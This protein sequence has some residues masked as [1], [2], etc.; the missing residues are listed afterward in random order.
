MATP[1]LSRVVATLLRMAPEHLIAW[2]G[3]LGVALAVV[4]FFYR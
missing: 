2:F 4:V 1:H 3:L